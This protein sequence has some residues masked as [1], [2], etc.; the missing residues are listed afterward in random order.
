MVY[1]SEFTLQ[2]LEESFIKFEM[3]IIDDIGRNFLDKKDCS[4]LK[5]IY[6]KNDL[7][8]NVINIFKM[9]ILYD[10][11]RNYCDIAYKELVKE[12]IE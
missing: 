3:D 7:L 1:V 2:C 8:T 4:D 6:N 12:F 11:A 10:I 9:D 5:R